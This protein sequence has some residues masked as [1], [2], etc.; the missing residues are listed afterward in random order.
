MKRLKRQSLDLNDEFNNWEIDENGVKNSESAFPMKNENRKNSLT[1]TQ[2]SQQQRKI[3]DYNNK[4]QNV[5]FLIKLEQKNKNQ[6]EGNFETKINKL[7]NKIA[8][9]EMEL[10]TTLKELNNKESKIFEIQ[11]KRLESFKQEVV[12]IEAIHDE[13]KDRLEDVTL[14]IKNL[15][16][17]ELD[18]YNKT[19]IIYED[20]LSYNNELEMLKARMKNLKDVLTSI[21]KNYPK[22]FELLLEDIE[23]EEELKE[24]KDKKSK[25]YL[26]QNRNF[27]K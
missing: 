6:L 21:E 18:N 22:E 24:L 17:D 5:E 13:M 15:I 9:N 11:K 26:N 19:F 23:I 25:F 27:N 12:K 10:E 3:K 20:Y 7:E 4:I 1:N 2:S 8:K 16:P 14:T